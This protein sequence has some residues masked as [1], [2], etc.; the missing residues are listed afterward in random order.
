MIEVWYIEK[1]IPHYMKVVFGFWNEFI[2][3]CGDI[4][5]VKQ[6]VVKA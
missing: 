6:Q 3:T 4:L 5:I 2:A 1:G